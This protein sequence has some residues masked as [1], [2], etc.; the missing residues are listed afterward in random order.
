MGA[1]FALIENAGQSPASSSPRR[2]SGRSTAFCTSP[3]A[4]TPEPQDAGSSSV[5]LAS[6]AI[7]DR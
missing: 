4:D 3:M 6:V 7:T 1:R 5:P 2:R